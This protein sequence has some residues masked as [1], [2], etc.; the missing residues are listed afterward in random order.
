MVHVMF[1]LPTVD[2]PGNDDYILA[3]WDPYQ[4][5]FVYLYLVYDSVVPCGE[6]CSMYEGWFEWVYFPELPL[7]WIIYNEYNEQI[8]DSEM[9]N[10][11]D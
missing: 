9:R 2:N 7:V 1:C 11:F 8:A 10:C 4:Q 3:V 6:G 5:E